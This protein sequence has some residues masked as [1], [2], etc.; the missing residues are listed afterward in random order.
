MGFLF[1]LESYLQWVFCFNWSLTSN[2]RL[3]ERALQSRLSRTMASPT[4]WVR[5]DRALT[6]TTVGLGKIPLPTVARSRAITKA[7]AAPQVTTPP[8]SQN[9]HPQP[10]LPKD[11][12]RQPHSW[13][14]TGFRRM[15]LLPAPLPEEARG[16]SAAGWRRMCPMTRTLP[17]SMMW[18]PPT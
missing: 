12:S 18:P 4:W 5:R 7:G 17:V 13:R 3:R 16:G 6:T 14:H 8:R 2:T 15:S 1:E 9:P 10:Q 11:H